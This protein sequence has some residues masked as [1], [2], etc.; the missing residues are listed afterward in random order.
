MDPDCIAA[1]RRNVTMGPALLAAALLGA[2]AAGANAQTPS[3]DH[4]ISEAVQPAPAADR[5]G[6]KVLGFAPDGSWTTL[7]QGSNELVC[8]ADDPN[9]EGWNVACYHESLDPFM[10]RGRELRGQGVTDGGE[11]ARR[12]WA[13]ASS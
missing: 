1:A 2:G 10:A 12:R 9:R 3:P 6:A 7:R 11:L 4:Q 13:E 8:L 5:A